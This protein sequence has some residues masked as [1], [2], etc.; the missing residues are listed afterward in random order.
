M[1]EERDYWRRL[2]S[3]VAELED[4]CWGA[5]QLEGWQKVARFS[6]PSCLAG[7]VAALACLHLVSPGMAPESEGRSAAFGHFLALAE[8]QS[9]RLSLSSLSS[10]P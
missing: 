1:V 8:H 2:H 4:Y 5:A 9:Q 7:V 10:S 3:V 6:A